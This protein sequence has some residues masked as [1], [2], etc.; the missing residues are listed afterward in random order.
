MPLS[1]SSAMADH[2]AA[3][4]DMARDQVQQVRHHVGASRPPP[5]AGKRTTEPAICA[6][7]DE[8]LTPR[9]DTRTWDYVW[10]SGVAGGLAGCAA[11][12]VVAPLD[13]VKILFQASNPQFAKYTGSSF[14]VATAMR[15]I[16]HS[17]GSRGL[18][19]GHSAT[20][21]RI[22]PYAGIKFLARRCGGC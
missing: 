16:Y 11:K 14:G 19:R 4:S 5:A 6:T 10:R 12:T 7:D 15:D 2:A 13:R 22:F 17:E 1:S 8:A 21:L 9:K 20:L 3:V 18:F